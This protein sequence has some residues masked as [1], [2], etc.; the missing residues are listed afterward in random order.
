MSNYIVHFS[1][2]TWFYDLFLPENKLKDKQNSLS[3]QS[4]GKTK[5]VSTVNIL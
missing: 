3:N 4:G 1:L 2:A 5:V